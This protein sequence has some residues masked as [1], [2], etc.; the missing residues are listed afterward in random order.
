MRRVTFVMIMAGLS[1][2]GLA[3][4]LMGCENNK[5][6]SEK[7]TDNADYALA[8]LFTNEGCKVWRFHDKYE[9]H[10]YTDCRGQTMTELRRN[11]GKAPCLNTLGDIIP[12]IDDE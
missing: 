9:Y 6:L 10:Y 12:T 5:P 8:L 1:I 7:K 2:I 4:L 11:C 3:L